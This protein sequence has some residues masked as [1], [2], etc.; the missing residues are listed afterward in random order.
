MSF[1]EIKIEDVKINPFTAIG[2]DWTLITAGN[3]EK[4]NTMTASWGNLGVTWGK[5]TIITYIRP[6]RYTR[7][8]LNENEIYTVSIFPNK[9]KGDLEYL[10]SVSGKDENKVAK[11]KLTPYFTD[12]TASFQEANMIFV[13]KKLYVGKI[14]EVNFLDKEIIDTSY[15][16]KD[17]HYV[18]ISEII[19]VLIKE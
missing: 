3:E 17:Y 6:Q 16:E 18:Y 11:T 2:D 12:G 5:P 4:F 10:G 8:F 19:K 1:K 7:K 9:Y 13:C 14:E 15:P